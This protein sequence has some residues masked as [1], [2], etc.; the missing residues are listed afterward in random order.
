MKSKPFSR[1]PA[2]LTSGTASFS[3]TTT[4]ILTLR[5]LASLSCGFAAVRSADVPSFGERQSY[6][7]SDLDFE[8]NLNE[9]IAVDWPIRYQDIAPWYDYVED[10][11]GVSGQAE[12][13]SQ[14]PD[15]KFLPPMEMTC[16]E[17]LVKDAIAK[18]FPGERMMT[19][20]RAAILTQPHRGRLPC[21]YCGPCSRDASRAPTSARQFHFAGSHGHGEGDGSSFQRG[22]QPGP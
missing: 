20:G 12:G 10:F 4:S 6:R 19:I 2:E 8:A 1:S 13:L 3:S 18:H 11:I 22:A 5:I 9:G 14:L 7:W 16:A 15:G 17:L 21:H